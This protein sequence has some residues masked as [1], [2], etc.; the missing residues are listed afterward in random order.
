MAQLT[1]TVKDEAVM[2]HIRALTAAAPLRYVGAWTRP[3]V[4]GAEVSVYLEDKM[5]ALLVCLVYRPQ[6]GAGRRWRMQV[7]L[8]AGPETVADLAQELG[9]DAGPAPGQVCLT[10][11][12]LPTGDDVIGFAGV[13]RRLGRVAV[14]RLQPAFGP[15]LGDFG[16][17]GPAAGPADEFSRDLRARL[18]S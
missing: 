4:T 18:R 5:V 2:A 9:G 3:D 10:Y 7:L 14:P 16:W 15:D 17:P 1:R 8:G 12:N 11:E 13:L 6:A